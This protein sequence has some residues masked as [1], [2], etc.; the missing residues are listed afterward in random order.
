MTEKHTYRI[1]L[2]EWEALA[3]YEGYMLAMMAL[4]GESVVEFAKN[5][6]KWR[7]RFGDTLFSLDA[8]LRDL[9]DLKDGPTEEK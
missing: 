3:L 8:T 5:I 1:D 6:E 4:T 7:D 9:L 2:P